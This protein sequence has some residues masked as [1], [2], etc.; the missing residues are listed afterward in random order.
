MEFSG[1]K[2]MQTHTKMVEEYKGMAAK[3]GNPDELKKLAQEQVKK[4]AVNHFAG[5]EQLLMGAMDQLS[6]YKLKYPNATE[7][8]T[9]F[10]GV[11]NE[12]TGKPLR[13]RLVP[14]FT[15]QF[16][17]ASDFSIDYNPFMAYRISGKWSAGLGWV[18]RVQFHSFINTV[19]LGRV[20]GPRL[21]TDVKWK[22][23]FSWRGEVEH[24]NNFV[25]ASQSASQTE[26]GRQLSWNFFVGV[27]KD[28]KF[29]KGIRGNIQVLYNVGHYIHNTSAYGDK[30]NARMGFEFSLKKRS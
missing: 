15:L 20:Y 28:Y 17:T 6:K 27:K 26:D 30:L 25:A 19:P 1:F 3:A 24:I 4:E 18:E 22:K 5:K 9:A 2:G 21:F 10:K 11:R 23:G 14:G 13:E 8:R 16:H 29:T 12:M 7:V